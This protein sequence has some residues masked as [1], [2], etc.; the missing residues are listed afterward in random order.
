MKKKFAALT[1]VLFA[2]F[3]GAGLLKMFSMV[4]SL[5]LG[6]VVIGAAWF[7]TEFKDVLFEK[8]EEPKTKSK[9]KKETK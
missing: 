9:T 2:L 6:L 1:L 4:V 5:G 7:L 3:L 8:E